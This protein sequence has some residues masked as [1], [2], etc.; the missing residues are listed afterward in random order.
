M[1][2]RYLS[3]GGSDGTCLGQSATELVSFHGVAPAVQAQIASAVT[4]TASTSTTPYGFTTSTQADAIV[5][6]VNDIRAKLIT[7]GVVSA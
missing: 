1:A 4:T 2:V 7:K 5:T 3:F 6:L